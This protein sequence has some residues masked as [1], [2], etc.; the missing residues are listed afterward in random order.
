MLK[1]HPEIK[2]YSRW[3]TIR[4]IIEGETTFRATDDEN[5]RRQLFQ[6]YVTELKKA[7]VEQESA[8]R[9][10]AMDELVGIL[11]SLDLEPYTRWSEAQATIESSDKFQGDAKFKS[12]SK[13]DVLTAFENHIKSLERTFNDARQ[14]QKAAR[15][16]KERRH[17]EQY[18]E[19]LEELKSQGKI[20][21]GSKWMNIRPVIQ[22]DPRYHA[23]LGQAGSTPLDL[24]WD[25]VEEE[26]RSLRG[27]RNDVLDV[28]DVSDYTRTVN[29]HTLTFLAR[30]NATR[31]PPRLPTRSSTLSWLL[32]GAPR[33]L[34]RTFLRSFSNASRIKRFAEMKKRSTLPIAT[35]AVQSTLCALG[36]SAWILPSALQIRGSKC[37]LELKSTK[38]IRPL[39]R[40][41]CANQHSTRSSAA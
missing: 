7:H 15:A 37:N 14:Q 16:R 8:T 29:Y 18:L 32:T 13:S 24:F 20:K 39:N 19:L 23:V 4:P 22:D 38:N 2:H 36:L 31:L 33:R 27:P 12:L 5:E 25:M 10:A 11:N 9:K 41:S 30:T 1:R 35:S 3:K 34:V 40:T 26:E 21:A 6:E 28:L 17:R